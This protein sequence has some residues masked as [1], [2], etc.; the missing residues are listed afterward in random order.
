VV[1]ELISHITTKDGLTVMAVKDSHT[2]PTGIKVSDE[3][4]AALNLS[5]DSFPEHHRKDW[6][7]H[8]FIINENI[9]YIF[10]N[11]KQLCYNTIKKKSKHM[12]LS[13]NR[14][15]FGISLLLYLPSNATEH[16][17]CRFDEEPGLRQRCSASAETTPHE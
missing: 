9:Y 5:R 11:S 12:S 8:R 13:S 3:E 6:F 15:S 17:L 4:F 1:L 16:P 2:Y 10:D 7:T 14:T